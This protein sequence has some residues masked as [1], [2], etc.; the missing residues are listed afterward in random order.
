MSIRFRKRLRIAHG[1]HLNLGLSGTS[2]SVGGRGLGATYGRRVIYHA[3][4]PGSGLYWVHSPRAQHGLERHAALRWWH[5]VALVF[6][7]KLLFDVLGG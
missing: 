6:L 7:V 4:V 2:V 5:L 1:V 3:G